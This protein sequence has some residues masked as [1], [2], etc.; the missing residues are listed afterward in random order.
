MDPDTSISH[1]AI[2]ML[3]I[4][5]RQKRLSLSQAMDLSGF[6]KERCRLAMENLLQTQ[7][8]SF[9]ANQYWITDVGTGYLAFS[10][11]GG[12]RN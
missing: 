4:L 5:K 11:S 2:S 10:K 7:L 6:D 8:V 1:D 9:E 3:R 12:I